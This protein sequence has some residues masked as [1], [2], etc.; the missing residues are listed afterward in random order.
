MTAGVVAV[1]GATGFIGRRLVERLKVRGRRVRLLLRDGANAP[2][3]ETSASDVVIGNLNDSNALSELVKGADSVI[4]VAGLTKALDRKRFFEV[5]EAGARRLARACGGRRLI[6]VS[7]LA[8]R[9]PGLSDYAASKRAGEEAVLEIA[10]S[11]AIIVR[12]PIVYGPGDR[13]TLALFR[14]ARLPVMVAPG[15]PAARVAFAEVDDVVNVIADLL[16]D[17]PTQKMISIGG[18]RPAGYSWREVMAAAA[19]AVGGRPAIVAAPRWLLTVAGS[20]LEGVAKWRRTPAMF[21]AGKA[22]EAFHSDWSVST[23]E[24]GVTAGRKY[25]PLD[26]GFARTVAW[27]RTQGWLR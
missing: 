25:I 22:A 10:G 14:A 15:N 12:P 17:S 23:S 18:D 13:E 9:E 16:T 7:S 27:Y 2:T 19:R 8:A 24:Q 3:L 1:T 20:T 11:S 26:D 21:T 6:H 4:H 5:N